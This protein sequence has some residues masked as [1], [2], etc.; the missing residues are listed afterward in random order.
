M[1][2]P[3]LLDS[4]D[5]KDDDLHPFKAHSELDLVAVNET[6][7]EPYVDKERDSFMPTNLRSRVSRPKMPTNAY[8]TRFRVY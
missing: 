3:E 4:D 8:K 7:I 2:V 5:C 1:K 6:H